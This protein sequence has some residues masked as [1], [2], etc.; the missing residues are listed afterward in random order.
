MQNWLNLLG[1]ALTGAGLALAAV[2]TLRLKKLKKR[3]RELVTLFIQD[4]SYVSFEHE[5]I[6][7]IARKIDDQVMFR[8]LV[9]CHQRGC[10][11]YRHLVSYYLSDEPSFTFSDLARLCKTNLI[12]YRWQEECWRTLLATREENKASPIPSD[13]F[14]TANKSPRYAYWKE[15]NR[16][17]PGTG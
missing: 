16:Q 13:L 17:G 3:N 6:D 15:A 7:E 5:L 14:L 9:S 10:D 12:T 4:A 8:Y 11:L 2:Q 1:I